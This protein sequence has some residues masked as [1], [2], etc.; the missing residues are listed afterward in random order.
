MLQE[1]TSGCVLEELTFTSYRVTV[2]ANEVV[3]T[4]L[5]N[6]YGTHDVPES[7]SDRKR[8]QQNF[9]KNRTAK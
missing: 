9:L 4:I 1:W 8:G 3:G 5:Q 7:K 6:I 2:N